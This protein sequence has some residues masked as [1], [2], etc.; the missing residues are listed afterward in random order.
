MSAV[1]SPTG[2]PAERRK[3]QLTNL[4]GN[5][6][7]YYLVELWPLPDQQ[8]FFR[9]TYGRV[10]SGAQVDERVTTERWVEQKIREKTRK[11]YREVALHRPAM[12]A[13]APLAP[14]VHHPKVQHVIDYIYAEAGEGI[15][16]YLAV[17][18][19]ALSPEQ[20]TQ[21]RKLLAL[22][23]I[24]HV[25][26]QRDTSQAN[27]ALLSGTVQN[28]YNAV[29]TQLPGRIDREKVVLKFCDQFDEQENRLNQ[30]EAAIA[31]HTVQ[32]QNPSVSRYDALGAD[33][34]LLAEIDHRYGTICDY[35]ER[36]AV[37][38]YNVRVR[39]I[40]TL[41]IPEERRR[42][43]ADD[44]GRSKVE[45]LFHGTAGQNVRH[46]LRTGLVCPKT[47]SHGRMFG[48]GVY[49]ANKCT[50]S[51]N[52]C[53]VR[54]RNGP[55]FLFLADVAIGKAFV[56]KD[57]MSDLRAAPRGHDSVW[58]KAGHTKAWGGALNFDEFIVYRAEQQT[59]RYLVLFD[60]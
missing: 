51:V 17:G 29:P 22:A 27:F 45:L 8:V 9:A 37:H 28:F 59:L 54:R 53:S 12:P 47:A 44:V 14:S 23:Q 41:S 43:S 48:H 20:I 34:E 2:E 10:G 25:S 21:G 33:I 16:S 36:T 40:F 18:V 55:Q 7:K 6:N 1:Y 58:G 26:W 50:K 4:D 60:R 5:N 38:G 24:Q 31:T 32:Q 39:D 3:F 42:F 56:A 15:A 19:D 57:A 13:T 52:Y 49:F 46:I 11:G 30:L 35:I